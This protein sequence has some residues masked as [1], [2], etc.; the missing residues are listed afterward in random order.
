MADSKEYTGISQSALNCLK[1][2][3]QSIGVNAPQG[4]GGTI[5]YH[6]VK[7][8]FSYSPA[9][10]KLSFQ[11]LSKPPVVPDSLIWQLLDGRIKKCMGT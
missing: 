6:G 10:Q 2:D 11:I 5:E 9:D 3:L 4:D 1:T 8:S 7:L